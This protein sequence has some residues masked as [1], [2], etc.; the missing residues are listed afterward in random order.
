M[1]LKIKF[2]KTAIK[3][4]LVDNFE[5]IL[6]AGVVVG[7][8]VIVYGA[9]MGRKTFDKTPEDLGTAA[10]RAKQHW[11]GTPTGLA[12]EVRGYGRE[13]QA[14]LESP[15][16]PDAYAHVA[17]WKPA[18]FK[19][20]H[21][22]GLPKLFP[23]QKL[24]GTA[25]SGPFEVNSGGRSGGSSRRGQH[26]VVLTGLVP[27]DEQTRAIREAYQNAVY[28]KADIDKLEYA[29]YT[30]ERAEVTGSAAPG[31]LNWT[32]PFYSTRAMKAAKG[33]GN[34]LPDVVDSEFIHKKL[35][36]PLGP[37]KGGYWGP[38]VACPPEIPTMTG[39]GSQTPTKRSTT[40]PDT[41]FADPA[42]PF[43]TMRPARSATPTETP[44]P[45]T[46]SA[47]NKYVLFR[48]F[49][50]SVE[51]GKRYRYRVRLAMTNPNLGVEAR[52]LEQPDLAKPGYL[53]TAWTDPTEVI[54]VPRGTRLLAMEITPPRR[55]Y[56]APSAK[57]MLVQLLIESGK[58]A[59]EE[60]PQVS[61]GK[62]LNYPNR[63][64]PPNAGRPAPRRRGEED[65][66]PL[67]VKKDDPKTILVNYITDALTLDMRGGESLGS[68]DGPTR[69]GEI[70]LLDP[71]GHLVVHN[72]IDD[73]AEVARLTSSP[74]DGQAGPA[75]EGPADAWR[76][77]GLDAL[78][79]RG[80]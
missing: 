51:R 46:A 68:R 31:D 12:G 33:F 16:N 53:Q 78:H 20:P 56:E 22:R 8:V 17:L 28:H 72:E 59:R 67:D 41:P 30:I 61:R 63:P 13:V 75:G 32:T 74:D 47:T 11:L 40:T 55:D 6:F 23:V 5:K 60:F 58:Q 45:G 66:L 50:Y 80:R 24:R 9:V 25:G 79:Q 39:A 29:G 35:T 36:F 14:L 77:S 37:L 62:V 42:S 54:R 73:L 1:K 44:Q 19:A 4:F 38:E 3:D 21:K 43:E 7:F 34:P 65:E 48:F 69:P 76:G 15:I 18:L 70:L 71:T 49:D 64:Y 27:I 52:Y 57:L 10:D 26:W 2:D